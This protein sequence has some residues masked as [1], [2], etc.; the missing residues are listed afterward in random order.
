MRV[1]LVSFLSGLALYLA[2]GISQLALETL[3]ARQHQQPLLLEPEHG[4]D[5]GEVEPELARQPLDQAQALEVGLR[6]E[7]RVPCS[8]LGLDEALL[9]VHAQG[10]RVHSDELRCDGDH[11]AGAVV[12]HV[13]SR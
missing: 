1:G 13:R 11:V 5:A 2:A 7:T 12:D 8:A 4:L 6:V 10:L 9:L 3:H